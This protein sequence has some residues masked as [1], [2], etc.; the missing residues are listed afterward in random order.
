MLFSHC[1]TFIYLS[2]IV[3]GLLQ[4]VDF[5]YSISQLVLFIGVTKSCI[6]IWKRKQISKL[7]QRLTSGI[8]APDYERGGVEEYNI[9][10][11]AINTV[12]FMVR[13]F[14]YKEKYLSYLFI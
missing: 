6:I 4:R 5:L 1:S 13:S 8:L 14:E 7:L 9:I 10:S 12:H 11:S 2:I 3:K